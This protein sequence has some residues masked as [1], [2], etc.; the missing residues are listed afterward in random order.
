M[1]KFTAQWCGP[2]QHIKGDIEKL[3]ADNPNNP[4]FSVDVDEAEAA[5]LE[6]YSVQAMP[7]FLF[8][9]NGDGDKVLKSVVGAQVSAVAGAL[10]DLK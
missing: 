5:F 9:K 8:F 1:V 2:C 4:F 7:T 6:K 10:S 3:A